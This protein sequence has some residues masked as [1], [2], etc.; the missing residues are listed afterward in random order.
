[1]QLVPGKRWNPTFPKGINKTM[2]AM[3]SDGIRN[4]FSLLATI[5][6][7]SIKHIDIQ[8]FISRI[9]GCRIVRRVIKE[10]KERMT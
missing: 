10:E 2:S 5:P 1:M 7:T 6:C 9:S 3:N 4:N 8:R